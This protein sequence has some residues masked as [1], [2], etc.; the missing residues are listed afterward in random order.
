MQHVFLTPSVHRH[1]FPRLLQGKHDATLM[2]YVVDRIR[3]VRCSVLFF[4]DFILR[5]VVGKIY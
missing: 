1:P 2:R 4:V 3:V 5:V